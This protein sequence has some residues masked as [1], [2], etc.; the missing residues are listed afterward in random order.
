[1]SQLA[2]IGATGFVGR[3]LVQKALAAGH[4]VRALAR[5]PEALAELAARIEVVRGDLFD[6]AS[7]GQLVQG[8]DAVI[9]VAGPPFQ[10]HHAPEPY[11]KASSDLVAA[12]RAAGA[13]RIITIAGAAARLPGEKLGVK[14][15]LLRAL[16]GR[17]VMPDIIRTKDREVA[18]I[19]SS[20]LDW[21]IIRPPRIGKGAPTGK[22]RATDQDL[23]GSTVDVEDLTDFILA[24][25]QGREWVRRAPT[26]A[27]V[28]GS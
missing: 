23:A 8:A 27:S 2:I 28:P 17:V 7:L 25:L 13:R 3:T 19:A 6:P 15:S 20:D 14:R 16:L 5:R 22:V 4:R 10:G 1:M 9:S 24:Q 12:A 26:I 11:E 18:V 21:T